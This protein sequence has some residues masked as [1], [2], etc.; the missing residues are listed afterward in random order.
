VNDARRIIIVGL[1]LVVS[2][3]M[4]F[5]FLNFSQGQ[6]YREDN[7]EILVLSGQDEDSVIRPEYG[8]DTKKGIP[9]V[10]LRLIF[11]MCLLA[12]AALVGAT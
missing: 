7:I 4:A 3:T 1:L 9:S 10:L 8:L 2:A 12:G 5:V 6:F 11:P